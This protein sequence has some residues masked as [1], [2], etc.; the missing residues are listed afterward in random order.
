M[1]DL[2]QALLDEKDREAVRACVAEVERTTSGEIVPMVV[3]RSHAYARAEAL[4]AVPVGM[5]L[6]LAAC[7]ALD[8]YLPMNMTDMWAYA[9]AF[10]ACYLAAFVILARFPAL[11]R[12]FISPAEMDEEVQEGALNA[13]HEHGLFRTR[14]ATGILVYVS[15]F[16]RRAWILADKGI[17]DKVDP[18]EW[19]SVVDELSLDIKAGRAAQGLCKAVRRCGALVAERF[20]VRPDDVNELADLVVDGDA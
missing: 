2:A 10:A 11:K 1:N 20:P 9:V 19:T 5:V 8:A 17:N 13:F 18:D 12:P 6:A 7:L 4:G 3:S 15:V 14:D 16:E